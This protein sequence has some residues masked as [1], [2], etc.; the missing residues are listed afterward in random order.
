MRRNLQS[1]LKSVTPRFACAEHDGRRQ[2]VAFERNGRRCGSEHFVARFKTPSL[3][4][5][6]TWPF[7]VCI[8]YF[9]AQNNRGN[10]K[11]VTLFFQNNFEC[12][13]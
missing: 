5:H 10:A 2:Q 9:R 1:V 7:S 6:D 3:K 4:S 12:F 8:T 13:D 11:P